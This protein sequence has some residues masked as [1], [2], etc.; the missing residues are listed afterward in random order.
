MLDDDEARF[1]MIWLFA[2]RHGWEIVW[3]ETADAA[4]LELSMEN[5]GFDLILLD[6]DLGG[7]TYVESGPGTGQEVADWL[8][9]YRYSPQFFHRVPQPRVVVHSWNPDGGKRMF[10]TLT[11]A[12][13]DA[14][15]VYFGK[16]LEGYFT[17]SNQETA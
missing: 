15:R 16:I 11:D 1:N 7:Q 10:N 17:A 8:A 6:H 9:R 2:L 14:D 4:I 12:G 13:Y 3:R 5:P